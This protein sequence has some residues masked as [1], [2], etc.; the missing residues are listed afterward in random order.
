MFCFSISPGICLIVCVYVCIHKHIYT[1]PLPWAPFR[2]WQFHLHMHLRTKGD[3]AEASWDWLLRAAQA[4]WPVRYSEMDVWEVVL[5][6]WGVFLFGVSVVCCMEFLTV[7]LTRHL[8]RPPPPRAPSRSISRCWP[9]THWV[10]QFQ[11]CF[12]LFFFEN[13]WWPERMLC[14]AF[15]KHTH[16]YYQEPGKI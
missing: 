12:A 8:I 13:R 4:V 5:W 9:S 11:F 14:C 15:G 2:P 6:R 7:L 16:L 3:Q 10:R 1:H